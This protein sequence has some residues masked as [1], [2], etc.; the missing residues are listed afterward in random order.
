MCS[1]RL[2]KAQGLPCPQQ[3]GVKK[4]IV[5]LLVSDYCLSRL[6]II[7]STF[8]CLLVLVVQ[9]CAGDERLCSCVG[10]GSDQK[11]KKNPLTVF[12][13]ES[14]GSNAHIHCMQPWGSRMLHALFFLVSGIIAETPQIRHSVSAYPY[15]H[16]LI[17]LPPQHT[18]S[19]I[20]GMCTPRS[21]RCCG[22]AFIMSCYAMPCKSPLR[23][24]S[25]PHAPFSIHNTLL[26]KNYTSNL[27]S[28]QKKKRWSVG[29]LLF[30]LSWMALMGPLVY[31][32]HLLSGS[33]LPFTAAYFGS[34]ALTLYFAVGVSFIIILKLRCIFSR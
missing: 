7:H 13:S 3:I 16:K 15:S 22:D 6:V 1:C 21:R 30:I 18:A 26:A 25:K 17:D 27:S 31:I 20:V 5:S 34:I 28:S 8:L 12:G 10:L 19:V 29:S 32:K 9:P 24:E 14:M 11:R 4:R 33:R 23:H 2:T